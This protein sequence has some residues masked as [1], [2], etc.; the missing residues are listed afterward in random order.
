MTLCRRRR[1]PLQA[2]AALE[3][4]GDIVEEQRKR[5]ASEREHLL[6]ALAYLTEVGRV[7][8]A[9]VQSRAEPIDEMEA[10]GCARVDHLLQLGGF[11]P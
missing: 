5:A 4:A 11:R 2:I 9:D 8:V 1:L 3:R 10:A 7:G 6:E